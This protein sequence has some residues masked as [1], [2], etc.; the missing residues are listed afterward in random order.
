[1]NCE[2]CGNYYDKPLIIEYQGREHAFDCF[3]CAINKLAPQ[4]ANCGV[5]IIGH[6]T[7]ARGLMC[8]CAHCARQIGYSEIQDRI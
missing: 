5:T 1:M 6:G 7:E 3:E 8:C 2:V 4:C